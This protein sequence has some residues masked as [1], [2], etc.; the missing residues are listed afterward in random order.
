MKGV[1]EIIDVEGTYPPL[2]RVRARQY[3]LKRVE[4]EGNRYAEA[5][6][7]GE[8]GSNI[9]VPIPS[10]WMIPE[11]PH[12]SLMAALPWY[13]ES[14]LHEPTAGSHLRATFIRNALF[15]WGKE[16]FSRL[17]PHGEPLDFYDYIALNALAPE[18][19][20]EIHSTR[21]EVLG[22]PWE[23]LIDNQN[24]CIAHVVTVRRHLG[25]AGATYELQTPLFNADS[26]LRV[27]ALVSRSGPQDVAYRAATRAIAS[28]V[29]VE[30]DLVRPGTLA[31][32]RSHVA[33][34]TNYDVLHLDCHGLWDEASQTCYLQLQDENDYYEYVEADTIATIV[35]E[36]GIPA[37]VLNACRSAMVGSSGEAAFNSFATSLLAKTSASDVLAMTYKYPV[38]TIGS[39][40]QNFYGSVATGKPFAEAVAFG[41]LDLLDPDSAGTLGVM[42]M[43]Q[44]DALPGQTLDPDQLTPGET[45]SLSLSLAGGEKHHTWMIP[46]S[47]TRSG[48]I[49]GSLIRPPFPSTRPSVSNGFR[50]MEAHLYHLDHVPDTVACVLLQGASGSGTT[51]LMREWMDW[52]QITGSQDRFV[53]IDFERAGSWAAVCDVVRRQLG[54]CLDRRPVEGEHAASTDRGEAPR[55]WLLWDHA[56]AIEVSDE[57]AAAQLRV[58]DLAERPPK[59]IMSY[60]QR[61]QWMARFGAAFEL[62]VRIVDVEDQRALVQAEVEAGFDATMSPERR[63]ELL[64]ALDSDA[65]KALSN[66]IAG[67]PALIRWVARNLLLGVDA[68]VLLEALREGGEKELRGFGAF[69]EIARVVSRFDALDQP[70][71]AA[72]TPI[73]ALHDEMVGWSRVRDVARRSGG[74]VSVEQVDRAKDVLGRAGLLVGE[75]G[76][77]PAVAGE[78]CRRAAET[79]SEP[80]RW[81]FAMTCAEDEDQSVTS[82]GTLRKAREILLEKEAWTPALRLS[83]K[84]HN[85]FLG[86]GMQRHA[87]AAANE[88]VQALGPAPVS[89]AARGLLDVA[90]VGF[91]GGDGGLAETC[92]ADERLLAVAATNPTI[93]AERR[94]ECGR[95]LR[96]RGDREGAKAEMEAALAILGAHHIEQAPTSNFPDGPTL[97][98]WIERE[99]RITRNELFSL[100]RQVGDRSAASAAPVETGYAV[101]SSDALR[102]QALLAAADGFFRRALSLIDRAL[103]KER[104]ARN[105]RGK[106][107]ALATRAEVLGMMGELDEAREQFDTAITLFGKIGDRRGAAVAQHKWGLAVDRAG[108]VLEAAHQFI[109]AARGFLEVGDTPT[110]ERF[111]YSFERFA[112][113]QG[114]AGFRLSL[115]NH[116]TAAGLPRTQYMDLFSRNW[117]EAEAHLSVSTE[118]EEMLN[119]MLG[120]QRTSDVDVP[121]AIVIDQETFHRLFTK[122]NDS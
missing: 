40:L 101:G 97:L 17:L 110:L 68:A 87:V 90:K 80:L 29:G 116:W 89:I 117:I 114:A 106:A 37:I 15:R 56:D 35:E 26:P 120:R 4:G 115:I 81:A 93:E 82:F 53:Y 33:K 63:K 79:M 18:G 50:G 65:S 85:G 48:L 121:Q 14:Y 88:L 60:H 47:Y 72:L 38:A 59:I 19:A 78:L 49:P 94:L 23:A 51:R 8:L 76:L 9:A 86:R 118:G 34:S 84:L 100:S 6:S 99:I 91:F 45:S 98:E 69:E 20:I 2:F 92:L 104:C 11:D 74:T 111:T 10:T 108:L 75:S 3:Y 27:L 46:S 16:A 41:A 30:I 42:T 109:D 107:V 103:V 28:A 96:L 122:R 95:V 58:L 70:D 62:V 57:E 83:Q 44:F 73:L 54:I 36:A 21:P 61:Q 39:F 52:Q 102:E 32:L 1:I 22:W 7:I 66:Y 5:I 55:T 43:E 71:V 119:S 67:I 25:A 24:V 12:A 64:G 13:L 113:D 105:E 31:G 112:R 77:H